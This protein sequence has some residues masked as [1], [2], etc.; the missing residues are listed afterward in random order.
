M[1]IA[2]AGCDGAG[3]T[4]VAKKLVEFIKSRGVDVVASKEPTNSKFGRKLRYSFDNDKRLGPTKEAEWFLKDRQIHVKDFIDPALEA[5]QTV[6]LDRYY[7]CT[8]A[9]SGALGMD[10]EKIIADN[11]VFAPRPDLV[12]YL[13]VSPKVSIERTSDRDTSEPKEQGKIRNVYQKLAMCRRGYMAIIPTDNRTVEEVATMCC[14]L[15][16]EHQ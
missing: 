2:F 15:F 3:K 4:T 7:Y 8:A 1:L 12:L 5:G 6:V 11:E 13:D 9:Y 14:K 10:P 16:L